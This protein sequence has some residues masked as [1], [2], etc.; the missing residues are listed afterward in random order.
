MIVIIGEAFRVMSWKTSNIIRQK[1][2]KNNVRF[3]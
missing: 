1:P 3:C 2:T